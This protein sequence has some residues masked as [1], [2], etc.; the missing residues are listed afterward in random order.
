MRVP[1]RR[2]EKDNVTSFD[3]HMT[4]A[5]FDELANKL[6]QLKKVTRF[7]WMHEVAVLA[8]GGDFSENAGYQAAKSRLR[9]INA[10]IAE[11]EMRLKKAVIIKPG[12]SG[13]AAL[14]SRVTIR[15]NEKTVTYTILGSSEINLAQR[16]ISH[17][18]PIG[19]ALMGKQAGEIVFIVIGGKKVACEILSID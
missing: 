14:G 7:K 13:R 11:I 4:Q 1:I 12:S 6:Q 16:I 3:P 2:S 10:S 5:K 15:M 18:S 8:E 9:G 17:N 19:A